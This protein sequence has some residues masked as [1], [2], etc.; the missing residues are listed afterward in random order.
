VTKF[1]LSTGAGLLLALVYTA[2]PLIV[3]VLGAAVAVFALAG[4]GL[5]REE[6]RVLTAILVTAF[7][8]RLALIAAMFVAGIPTHSDLSVGTLAGDDA[9]YLGR[10]LRARDLLLGF[11]GGRYDFFVVTDE[12]GRTSYLSLLT[13]IQ[14][15]LGPTPFSMRALNALFFVGG[16]ALLFRITRPA[17]GAIAAFTGL[18]IVLFLPSLFFSSVSLLKESLYF[19]MT[20]AL[21]FCCVR[22]VKARSLAGRGVAIAIGLASL[23]LLADLRRGAVILTLAG[24]GLALAVRLI[25]GNRWRA[26]AATALIV[27]AVVAGLSQDAMRARALDSVVAAAKMHGGH[28]FT[29]GHAYKLLDEDFYMNPA[30]PSAWPLTLTEPQAGRFLVRAAISFL[31]TPLPW[32]MT[33]RSELAYMPEHVLWYVGL[34][35]LPVGLIAG[36]KRDPFVTSLLIGYVVPTAA[37]LAVT[38]GNVGTLLR[39]RGL[40]TP[41]LLWLSVVGLLAVANA[42]VSTRRNAA[43]PTMPALVPERPTA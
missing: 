14:V 4:R 6:R 26:A 5:P 29:V 41:Y 20:S 42:I 34:A 35:F 33:S 1:L 15:L 22:V 12:Y 2:S 3:W 40:V 36:W 19:L 30:A 23:W 39:L 43:T 13:W 9:Y 32:E 21:L 24:L 18:T 25:G 10:A 37:A 38:N 16:A 7:A 8:A 27:I 17:F 11:S 31:V 28:V